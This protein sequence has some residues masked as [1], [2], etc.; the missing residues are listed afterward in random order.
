M[1]LALCLSAFLLAFGL[2]FRSPAAGFGGVLVTGYFYG[3]L[4]ANFLDSFTHFI[5]D[6][7]VVGYYAALW[8]GPS[9]NRPRPEAEALRRWTAALLGWVVFMFLLPLQPVLIQMVGLRGNAFLVPFLLVGARLKDEELYRVCVWLAVLNLIALGFGVAEFFRGVPAFYPENQVTEIIY[10]SQD[11]AGNTA[12]RIP[13]VFGNAHSYAGTMVMTVP[14]LVGAWAVP[15]KKLWQRLLM[16]AGLGAAVGGVFLAAARLPVVHLAVLMLVVT[17]S[18]QLRFGYW[19]TWVLLLAGVGYLVSG[20]ERMQ[21]FLSLQKTEEVIGRIEGSVNMG[22]WELA[23]LYPL[24]NGLG[25]GGTSVPFFLQHLIRNPVT[26][27]NEYCRILLEQGLVGL[28][29][30]SAFITW[31]LMRPA[32]RPGDPWHLGCRLLWYGCLGS[33]AASL[34]GTG[35]MTAIPQ[36]SLLFLSIGFLCV[37]GSRAPIRR[38]RGKPK[39]AKRVVEP[40]QALAVS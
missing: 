15:G 24:G 37:R 8:G 38:R 12:F 25:G 31:A 9:A 2:T 17:L 40:R 11:V 13:A 18:G 7:A 39:R 16:L 33:F 35:L 32:P 27:E 30:W 29:L 20:E 6:A 4:R 36:T 3:I 10:R 22:F 14:W 26:M 21:R 34:L 5:F 28:V 23:T 19:L 1:G